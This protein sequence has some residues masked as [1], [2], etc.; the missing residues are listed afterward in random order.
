MEQIK[1]RT[2]RRVFRGLLGSTP[3]HIKVFRADTIAAKA[4]K[5]LR[6]GKGEREA[7]NLAQA[8]DLGLPCVEPLAHG[9]ALDD[10]H[11]NS[12]VVTRSVASRDFDFPAPAAVATA[13]GALARKVH[14]AG[15]EP[16]DLHPGNVLVTD[17]GECWR[18]RAWLTAKVYICK[19][20]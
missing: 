18:E 4:R 16:L 1:L 12:F 5:V 19:I 17:A 11:L 9:L 3:V 10:G 6:V 7:K 20:D 8:R 15:V 2:V 14:D 13:G